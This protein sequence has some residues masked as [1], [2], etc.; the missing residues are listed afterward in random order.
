MMNIFELGFAVLTVGGGVIGGA[1]GYAIDGGLGAVLGVLAG[2][3]SGVAAG[4]LF[5]FVLAA[6]CSV[7]SGGPLFKPSGPK[8]DG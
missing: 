5:I 8:H 1:K 7:V 6:S 2:A 3:A 4:L